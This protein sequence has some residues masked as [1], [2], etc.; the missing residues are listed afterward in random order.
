MELN[1]YFVFNLPKKWV[2]EIGY[3]YTTYYS[4]IQQ[5]CMLFITIKI[6][7]MTKFK[8]GTYLP[9]IFFFLYIYF[10]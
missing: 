6:F 2:I 3:V 9:I 1:I 5:H 4:I 8:L 7:K 10:M